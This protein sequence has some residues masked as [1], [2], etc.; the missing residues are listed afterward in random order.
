[1]IWL[2]SFT[3]FEQS[4]LEN[5]GNYQILDKSLEEKWGKIACGGYFGI[6]FEKKLPL[7]AILCYYFHYQTLCRRGKTTVEMTFY[8]DMSLQNP[9]STQSGQE[10]GGG[11]SSI[12]GQECRAGAGSREGM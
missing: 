8:L 5:S 12:T 10:G 2:K 9:I 7:T 4:N 3:D 1:L 6:L 11:F